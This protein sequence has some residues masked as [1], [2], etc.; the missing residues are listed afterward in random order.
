MTV[1]LLKTITL[2]LLVVAVGATVTASVST[3]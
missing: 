2:L 3:G 1:H